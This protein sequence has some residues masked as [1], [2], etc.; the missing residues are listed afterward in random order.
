MAYK[1]NTLESYDQQKRQIDFQTNNS[2]TYA[3]YR[4]WLKLRILCHV[5][6]CSTCF[7]NHD[8]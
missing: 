2:E 8:A 4:P 7:N 5:Q 1:P 6:L 3:K